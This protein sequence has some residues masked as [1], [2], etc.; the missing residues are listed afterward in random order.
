VCIGCVPIIETFLGTLN[1]KI[2]DF[3]VILKPFDGRK[4]LTVGWYLLV[5]CVF[6]SLIA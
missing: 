1:Y 5:E 4:K 6:V 2:I 3:K